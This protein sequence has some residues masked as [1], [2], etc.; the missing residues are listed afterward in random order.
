MNILVHTWWLSEKHGSEFA[1]A[2][3]FIKGMSKRHRL[4]VLVE[5][6]SYR[7][8][9]LTEINAPDISGGGYMNI[10]NV[11]VIT[12]P[13]HNKII[14]ALCSRIPLGWFHYLLFNRWERG[15][16]RFIKRSGLLEKIDLIHYAAPVGY[17]EPGFLWRFDKPYVWGP[18]GGMYRIPRA[19]LAEYP[20]K[21]RTLARVKNALNFLQFHSRRIKTVFKRSDVLIACT[22][23]QR[24]MVNRLLRKEVCRYLPENGIDLETQRRVSDGFLERKFSGGAIRV[25]WVGRNDTRKNAKLLVAALKKCTAENFRCTF[26]GEGC[27][28]LEAH[29]A[30]DANLRSR[31]AFVEKLP[32]E[33]V[34]D[35]YR[36]AHMMA[37]TSSMEAN[38]TVLF[39]AMENCVPVI[40]V[41]HCGMADVVKDGVSGMKVTVRGFENMAEDFAA[42]ID[43]VCASPQ[44]LLRFAKNIKA[45][46]YEYSQEYRMDFFEACYKDAVR[47]FEERRANR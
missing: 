11:N 4:Y 18:F 5:S 22:Q 14:E 17:R 21:E 45:D 40:T 10:P 38:T 39:E 32:R 9:D 12:V 2:Y 16:Y 29:F 41:D 19:F 3:N 23:T 34:V 27:G 7:W 42:K 30:D 6:N 31:L 20:K 24:A 26:V 43:A 46:S 25:L 44:T 47:N 35:M 33:T 15:V 13:Y 8:D 28:R 36:D 37:I 1:V